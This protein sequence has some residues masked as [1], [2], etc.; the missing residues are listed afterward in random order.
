MTDLGY[1][2]LRDVPGMLPVG[3]NGKLVSVCSPY[4]WSQHGIR[5][6][7]LKTV[8]VGNIRCTTREWLREFFVGIS[9]LRNGSRSESESVSGRRRA[10][11]QILDRA[12]IKGDEPAKLAEANDRYQVMNTNGT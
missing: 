12:G 4:R 10:A 3:R 5:G 7:V 1:V 6:V 8:Q 2:P 9:Q 11:A